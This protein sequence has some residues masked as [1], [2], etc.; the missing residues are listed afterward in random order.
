M[1]IE[2]A[3]L[4]DASPVLDENNPFE[5]MMQRFDRAAELLSLDAG[6][7]RVLRHPE[8]QI[9]ISCPG[10]HGQRRGGGVHG[11]PR[12]VQHVRG[13]A[14]GG[15]RYDLGVTLDEVTALAAWMTW[16]CA[17][18][19]VPFG[20][21]KGGVVCEPTRLLD[22]ANSSGSPVA[23]RPRSSIRSGRNRTC[24]RPT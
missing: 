19:D 15:I 17:V 18:V 4:R 12:P 23:T 2:N 9:I 16:K 11:V 1:L 10:H 7:Y 8:K 13:P 5:G 14:K 22:A 20:G 21:A 24:Q 6:L 3:P